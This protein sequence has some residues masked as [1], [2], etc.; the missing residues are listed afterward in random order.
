[1]TNKTKITF[2]TTDADDKEISLDV[3][4]PTSS[5]VMGAKKLYHKT[6][7]EALKAGLLPRVK[8]QKIIKEQI[9]DEDLQKELEEID[10]KIAS[11]LKDIASGGIKKSDARKL[12]IQ[13]RKDR[14]TRTQM[15]SAGNELDNSS[16]EAQAE[17]REFDYMVAHCTLDA[18]NG[19]PYFK[20]LD[21]YDLRK[22]EKASVDAAIK[23]AFLYHQVDPDY[24][25]QYPENKFLKEYG[26]CDDEY[27]LVDQNGH[28]CDEDFK[29]IND[30]GYYVN[31][32]EE[33]VDRDGNRINED[34]TPFVE[35]VEFLND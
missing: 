8:V 15:L 23:F 30:R 12:A 11:S 34:G 10:K 28:L 25:K 21:D 31:D 14:N 13:V 7:M 2:T 24:M 26:F 17:N 18:E 19:E 3:R 29:P 16:C 1:M 22:D 32:R 4:K 20:G 35:F 33:I 9:W 27:R 5:V 6:L